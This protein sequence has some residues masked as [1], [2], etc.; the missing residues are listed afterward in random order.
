MGDTLN[1]NLAGMLF[2]IDVKAYKV[3]NNYLQIINSRFSPF[4]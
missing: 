1:I 2:K 3:L 4:L